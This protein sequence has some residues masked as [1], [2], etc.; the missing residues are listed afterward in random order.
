M[1]KDRRAVK[2]L[3]GDAK[4]NV[5]LSQLLDARTRAVLLFWLPRTLPATSGSSQGPF[6]P[7]PS[8][9]LLS[10]W[11]WISFRWKESTKT[12][13]CP[14]YNSQ[15]ESLGHVLNTRNP[16]L[17][18]WE[19]VKYHSTSTCM[20]DRFVK[21][22]IPESPSDLRPDLVTSNSTTGEAQCI[23]FLLYHVINNLFIVSCI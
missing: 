10:R 1:L 23:Y 14:K 15:P 4:S 22:K 3:L 12:S 9:H 18:L 20:G 17:V 11:D 7:S 13:T 2:K 21:Q 16:M 19:S 8:T 6:S 5:R